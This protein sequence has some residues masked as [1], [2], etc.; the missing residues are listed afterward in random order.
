MRVG[1]LTLEL[2]LGEAASLKDK[3]RV[4]KSLTARLR[5]KFNV[6]VAEVGQQDSWQRAVLGVVTVSNDTAHID[7]SLAAVVRYVEADRTCD[8]IGVESEVI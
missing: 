4:V 5:S 2:H 3:R 6:A 1:L 8:L 7:R